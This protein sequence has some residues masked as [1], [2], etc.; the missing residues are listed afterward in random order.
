[1]ASSE[2]LPT[3][4]VEPASS[5][6]SESIALNVQK[7]ELVSGSSSEDCILEEFVNRT[8]SSQIEVVVG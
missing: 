8:I 5:S 3:I 2:Q 4:E 1:M 6:S 7:E